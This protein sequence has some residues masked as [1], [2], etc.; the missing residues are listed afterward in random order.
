LLERADPESFLQGI[1]PVMALLRAK[2]RGEGIR[3]ALAR[4]RQSSRAVGL[5]HSFLAGNMYALGGMYA[6]IL[7]RGED[8]LRLLDLALPTV[9][10]GPAWAVHQT[11]AI[12]NAVEILWHLG[13]QHHLETLERCLEEKTLKPDFRFPETDGRLS[14]ARVCALGGRCEEASH[15]FARA[16][17]VLEE[18]GARPQR[19]IADY[20]EAWM[21]LRRAQAGDRERALPL[22][23][24]AVAQF[25]SIGM[26][27]WIRRA[28]AIASS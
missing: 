13:S 15:W 17:V 9:E 28:E 8:A 1:L 12:S 10:K 11:Q 6:A 7:G 27:G 3:E 4:V 24:A 23:G 21:Y 14:M 16:R 25:E 20:D 26:P 5:H 18:Q 2:I 22:L 19:A